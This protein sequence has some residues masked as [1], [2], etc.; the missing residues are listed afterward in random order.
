MTHQKNS[1]IL[2]IILWIFQ[3]L[4]AVTFIWAGGMKLFQP[5]ELPWL[6]VK[7]NPE[8]VIVSGILDI[9]AGFGLTLPSLLRIHPKMTIYAAYGIIALMIS[10]SIFHMLRGE[11]NQIGF[12]IFILLSA[13]FIAW[14]RQKKAPI[15]S[16]K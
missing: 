10:A 13:I 2:N 3:I 6:W 16:K 1:N 7:G 11:G 4:L 14:G 8:L 5:N 9:L 15:T 12:N